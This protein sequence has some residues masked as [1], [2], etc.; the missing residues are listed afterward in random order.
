MLTD[1]SIKHIADLIERLTHFATETIAASSTVQ[2][3]GV[4]SKLV[5]VLD[6]AAKCN[7]QEQ[8]L[9]DYETK[10]EKVTE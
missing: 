4:V 6:S 9:V 10:E 8:I 2:I 3:L 5:S 7:N 1:D